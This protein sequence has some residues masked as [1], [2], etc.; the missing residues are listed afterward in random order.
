MDREFSYSWLLGNLKE[1]GIHFVVRLNTARNPTLTD[2]EGR[3]ITLSLGQGERGSFHGVY[4]RGEVEVNVGG[5]WEKGHA[6]PLWV[7]TDL[8]PQKA[9]SIYR[10]RMKIEE[11]FR[12]LKSV[13][14]LERLMNKTGEYMEGMVALVLLAY[15]I[16]LVLGEELRDELYG[17]TGRWR[18]YSG[19]FVLLVV[20]PKLQA[21]AGE[22]VL[23]HAL[24]FF[25]NI[26][27][28]PVPTHV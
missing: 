26:L 13:F 17:G 27:S 15:A 23:V 5:V 2:K 11:G 6:E 16:G 20:R 1:A 21:S 24:S 12:D 28:P 7:I 25:R 8:D 3:K 4:Y 14:G 18:L 19:L 9:L 22:K 10:K